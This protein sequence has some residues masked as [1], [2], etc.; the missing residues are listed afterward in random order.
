MTRSDKIPL[1]NAADDK[2]TD[3]LMFYRYFTANYTG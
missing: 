2:L 3:T 1:D